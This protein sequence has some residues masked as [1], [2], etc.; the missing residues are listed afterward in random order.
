MIL[1]IHYIYGEVLFLNA[2]KRKN[3]LRYDISW[4]I[5]LN[6]E[7]QQ[8][9]IE[10]G[11]KP[12]HIRNFIREF[13]TNGNSAIPS[14]DWRS[15]KHILKRMPSLQLVG[16]IGSG[17]T[18]LTKT[19][20]Q[21][22]NDHIY[23]VLDSH[24]EYVD[25][26]GIQQITSDLKSSCRI[27]VPKLPESAIAMFGVYKNLITNNTFPANYV[28]VIDEAFRYKKAGIKNLL[29][30]SRKFIKVLAVTQE[31]LAEYCPKAKVKPYIEYKV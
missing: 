13:E 15:L 9:V 5:A 4:S 18:H 14:N 24:D 19:L 8:Q 28:L 23:I 10:K 29:A 22:D 26:P 1:S 25:L 21:N 11:I 27:I 30:E 16:D 17:K 12:D 31:S 6:K 2:K 3:D 20:I 7:L